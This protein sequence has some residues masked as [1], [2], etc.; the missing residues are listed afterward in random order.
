[1]RQTLKT[2]LIKMVITTAAALATLM[3]VACESSPFALQEIPAVDKYCLTAQKIVTRTELPMELVVHDNFE[4][5][6]KSK[7]VIEGPTIQQYNWKADDGMVLGISCKLKSSDH[8]NLIFGGGSAGPD[9]LCQY[10]NQAV[11]RLLT[12]QV[13]SPAFTRVVFDPSEKLNHG[14]DDDEEPGMTGPDWLAPFTMTYIEEG[15]LHIAT[16]GFVVNF[17]DPQYAEAP[18]RFRGVHYCHLVAPE[19]LQALMSGE[20]EAGAVI[21]REVDLSG[22]PPAGH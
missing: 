21:G 2:T 10:M 3:L 20:A 6:V 19:Y 14:D 15:A 17:L 18:E 9:S 13:S 16:K 1:M 8:L 11:F 5:F 12:T 22:P 4:A 7:A